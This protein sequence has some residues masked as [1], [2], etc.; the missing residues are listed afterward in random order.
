MGKLILITNVIFCT[1]FL[2][3]AHSHYKM[4]IKTIE[5]CKDPSPPYVPNSDNKLAITVYKKN[6][7]T[8]VKGTWTSKEDLSGYF[9]SF[10]YGKYKYGDIKYTYI[11]DKISCNNVIP[12][13]LLVASHVKYD[14]KRCVFYK[15]TYSFDNIDLTLVDKGAFVFPARELG[16]SVIVLS[17]YKPGETV[18]CYKALIEYL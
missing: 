12:K 18:Y 4:N 15:G 5:E 7:K 16:E 10:K 8:L 3:A 14:P 17:F 1:S 9:W 2:V 11:Y 13:L 6:N